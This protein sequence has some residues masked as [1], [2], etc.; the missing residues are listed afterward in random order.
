MQEIQLTIDGQVVSVPAGSTL[1]ESAQAIGI[2]VPV[3][4]FHELTTAEGICRQCVV[5]VVG[6][7]LL[8]PAC[9]T[10]VQA[11][12]VVHT[13]SERVIRARRTILE[14]L[15][16]SVD[17]SEAAELQEQIATYDA[18]AE[19]FVGAKERGRPLIDDNPFY[20]REYQKCI[21]CWRCVQ[22]CAYDLQ[23]TY[24]LAFGGRG[25]NSHISTFLEKP[26]P[27]TTCVFCGNC[28]AV[29]P[30]GALKGKAESLLEEGIPF[31]EISAA[32]RR[33]HWGMG[34]ENEG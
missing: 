22:A 16:A 34:S 18:D 9:V 2:E 29:C 25:F 33:N 4:C 8:Q 1:L 15:A 19:R 7:R 21:Q 6:R 27:E 10:E 30:T 11:G 5:E 14:M 24:A 20:V 28:V 17:F 3:I 13:A 26:L 12:M 32:T 23:F 31:D